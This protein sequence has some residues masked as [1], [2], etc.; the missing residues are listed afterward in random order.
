MNEGN[1]MRMKRLDWIWVNF[2]V[3]WVAFDSRQGVGDRWAKLQGKHC[4]V[5]LGIEGL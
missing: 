1:K 4:G 2:R 3:C 5:L